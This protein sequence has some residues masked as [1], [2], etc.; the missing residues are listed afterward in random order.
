MNIAYLKD[1]LQM[2]NFIQINGKS[3]LPQDKWGHRHLQFEEQVPQQLQFCQ[4]LPHPKE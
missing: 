4:L 3:S 2:H 1:G